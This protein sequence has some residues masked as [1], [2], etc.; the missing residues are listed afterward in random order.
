V[1]A[2]GDDDIITLNLDPWTSWLLILVKVKWI[3]KV[4]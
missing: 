1:T 2:G 4:V 3:L